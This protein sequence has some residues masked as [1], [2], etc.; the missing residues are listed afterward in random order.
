MT[1][2]KNCVVLKM[3]KV[4]NIYY[5]L[6]YAFHSLNEKDE[7]KY[8][9]EKF[10]YAADLFAA[11]LAN[12][13]AKQIKRGLAKDYITYQEEMA[14]PKGRIRIADTI[15]KFS[16][17]QKVVVCDVDEYN[18]NTY[19]NQILKAVILLLLK[20]PDVRQEN[21]K[22]LRGLLL[23]FHDVGETDVK[24]IKWNLLT[25][26]RYN[27]QYKM[28]MYICKLIIDGMIIGEE[29]EGIIKLREFIDDQ[30]MHVLYEKFILEYYKRHYP[31]FKVTQ[32]QI[33]WNLDDDM[34]F[35]LP[36][37][38]SDIMLGYQGKTLIID[39]KFYDSSLQTNSRYGNQTIHSH[40][41]YQIYAYV[42]NKD[43]R[44][45]KSVSGMLL[46]ANT[47]G[48]NPDVDYMMDGSKISVKT[49]D[50]NCDFPDVQRQLN[51]YADN[52]LEF[53]GEAV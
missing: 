52:W 23:Y 43:T 30:Q 13:I 42:K 14:S 41:L 40:N 9:D 5:M 34:D 31:Q 8:S 46:Y 22:K 35:L 24:H 1:G 44:S 17:Q 38:R 12:G 3:I 32:S 18:E 48:E 21:K 16:V 53:I 6:A 11:I 47:E 4:Q 49:L 20:S 26:T 39:A 2:L 27:S 33:E 28:L 51:D 7:K 45:D 36:R 25:Y 10:E 37:M 29:D 19:T 50:L 15:N